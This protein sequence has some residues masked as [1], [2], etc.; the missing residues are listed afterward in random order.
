MK[1]GTSLVVISVAVF[2][3]SAGFVLFGGSY[4]AIP[5]ALCALSGGLIMTVGNSFVLENAPNTQKSTLL[6]IF[7]LLVT[8]GY[9]SFVMLAGWGMETVGLERTYQISAI[10]AFILL[11]LAVALGSRPGFFTPPPVE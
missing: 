11:F 3:S 7:S 5:I 9:S 8:T 4:L 6:S 2:L 1:A 10:S